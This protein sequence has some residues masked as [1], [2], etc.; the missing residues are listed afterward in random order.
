MP[1]LGGRRG[2]ERKNRDAVSTVFPSLVDADTIKKPVYKSW[3]ALVVLFKDE[4]GK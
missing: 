1:E 3:R 2:L 4:L